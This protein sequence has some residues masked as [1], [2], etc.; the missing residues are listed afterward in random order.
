M[1]TSF[2]LKSPLDYVRYEEDDQR[3][4]IGGFALEEPKL[5]WLSR[6]FT[7]AALEWLASIRL[8]CWREKCDVLDMLPGEDY[9]DEEAMEILRTDW[10]RYLER[11]I[12][13]HTVDN[14]I[15]FGFS[16]L[17]PNS[18]GTLK[19]SIDNGGL[20]APVT[21]LTPYPLEIYCWKICEEINF[22][23]KLHAWEFSQHPPK[24]PGGSNRGVIVTFSEAG[25]GGSI[26]DFCQ[27]NS[28]CI[29]FVKR[30][31]KQLIDGFSR[32]YDKGVIHGDIKPENMIFRSM[33]CKCAL[34]D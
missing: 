4:I 31:M 22:A 10:S 28:F 20:H 15:F 33:G 17:F 19:I 7:S 34:I 21:S 26:W 9:V 2:C 13:I 25:L 11:F 24:H 27:K 1:E 16:P 30:I 32:L 5:L 23:P 12:P 3:I 14:K 18:M 29:V 6:H 8:S